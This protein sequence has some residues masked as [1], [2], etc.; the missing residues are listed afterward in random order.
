MSYVAYTYVICLYTHIYVNHV[1]THMLYV[2]YTH[3]YVNQLHTH[4]SIYTHI[5]E[6]GTYAYVICSLYTHL[7]T[8]KYVVARRAVTVSPTHTGHM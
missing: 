2:A 4:M 8:H 5:C 7:Y 1:H 3:I 6:S